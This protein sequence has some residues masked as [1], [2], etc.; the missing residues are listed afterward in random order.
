MTVLYICSFAI[1][2]DQT[3]IACEWQTDVKDKCFDVQRATVRIPKTLSQ[4]VSNSM[5]SVQVLCPVHRI[6]V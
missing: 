4:S 1:F 5:C 3:Y 2:P 6:K